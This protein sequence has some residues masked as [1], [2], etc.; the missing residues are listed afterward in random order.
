MRLVIDG[1]VIEGEMA[2]VAAALR[3]AREQSEEDGRLVIEVLADGAPASH[4]LDDP[5]EGDAGHAELGVVTAD[6]G[7]FLR[8][9]LLDAKE[10]LAGT[11][12]DQKTAAGMIDRGELAG[13]VGSLGLILEGW[14]G[15]QTVVGQASII[16]GVGLETLETA[17]VTADAAIRGLAADLVTLRDAVGGEDWSSLSDVLSGDLDT[18]AGQWSGLIDALVERV[19][20]A[21]RP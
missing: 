17:G 14:Q 10:A 9:T 21:P 16:A 2:G 4:L 1:R 3:A 13:A 8:E 6:R 18:R 7:L 19:G 12:E 11:R 5:P 15:V 20:G